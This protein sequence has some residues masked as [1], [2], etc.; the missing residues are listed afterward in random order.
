MGTRE[1]R[2]ELDARG[3]GGAVDILIGEGFSEAD[4]VA[5]VLGAIPRTVEA[6]IRAK[7]AG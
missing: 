2:A 7:A 3:Y 1:V 4:A 5:G 6:E